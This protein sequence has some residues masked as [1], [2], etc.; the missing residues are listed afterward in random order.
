[1]AG[2]DCHR[3]H[4]AGD[5]NDRI[6]GLPDDLLHRILL[7]LGSTRAAARTSVLSCRWRRVWAHLPDLR[8]GTCDD[9]PGATRLDTVERALDAYAAP[10]VRRLDVAMHCHGL[11]VRA[12]GVATWLRFAS[13]HRVR[14][15]DIVVPSQTRFLFVRPRARATELEE[16]LE[17]PVWDE[18]ARIRLTLE[19]RWR[20]RLRSAGVFTALTDL[21]IS[22]ATME[23]SELGTLVSSQCPRL[24]NLYLLVTL[25]ATSNVSIRSDSLRSLQIRVENIHRLEVIASNLEV[26]AMSDASEA[27]VSAPKLE[28]VTWD[29]D[30]AYDPRR[31]C[32]PDAGRHIRLLDLGS[33]CVAT[34]LLQR[35]DKA[36]VLKLSLNLCDRT[37]TVGYTS[38]VNETT[39]FPKC[40]TLR[41]RVSLGD[42]YHNFASSML[43]LLRSCNST[44]KVSVKVDSGL[45]MKRYPCL[46]SCHC[47][48]PESR[49]ADDITLDALEEAKITS[50]R[51]S[52]EEVQFVEQLARCHAPSLKKV[53]INCE[54]CSDGPPTQE[55]QEKISRMFYPDVD[56]KFNVTY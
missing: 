1:M 53:V 50:I 27:H 46:L 56:V 21:H 25:A 7:R 34:S 30:I 38:F 17:L 55:L 43:H 2:E 49:K 31:H 15:L 42:F 16:E 47:R 13:Q 44:R 51:S 24:T 14:K 12:C 10:A 6:S 39:K 40:E 4:G 33:K 18:A 11:R 19:Q 3:R 37:G 22:L 54:R 26:P 45:P 48:L 8:L 41:L 28:E 23:A 29:G 36:D 52:N 32:F 20:L 35:F 9:H 5:D